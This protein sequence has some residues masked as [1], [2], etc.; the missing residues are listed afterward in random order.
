MSACEPDQSILAEG[1]FARLSKILEARGSKM[2]SGAV[3]LDFGS[4]A[5]NLVKIALR[6]GLDAYGCDVDFEAATY[7]QNLVAELK[8]QGR[9]REI[10]TDRVGSPG[11][12]R[13]PIGTK[14]E[15]F[16]HYRL[17]FDDAMFDF[18]I[19]TEVLEHVANY[20]DVVRELHRVM[21]PGA[22]FL[23]MFPP[24]FSILES[25]TNIPFGGGFNPDWWLKLWSKS[26]LRV[27]HH[28]Q[29]DADEYFTWTRHYLD[30]C[31]NY[32]TKKEIIDAFSGSFDVEF[33][34]QEMFKINPKTRVFGLPSIY[35]HFRN[36]VLYGVRR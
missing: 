1:D 27:W 7:D 36:R 30:T 10:E 18:V 28:K 24:K 22:V 5:G 11:A 34:E 26:G 33:V 23:H 14:P 15:A 35:S 19:S 25:H 29:C 21:K 20:P 9:L 32:L 16:Q 31:V 3:V 6:Q 2:T 12:D 17:P 8:A 13:L 4:G